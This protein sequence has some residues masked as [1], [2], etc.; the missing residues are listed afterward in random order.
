MSQDSGQ[1]AHL[2]VG[3]LGDG[4][5]GQRAKRSEAKGYDRETIFSSA[6]L[7]SLLLYR[8]FATVLSFAR[9]GKPSTV[10]TYYIAADECEWDCAPDG[11]DKMTGMG[12]GGWRQDVY[13]AWAA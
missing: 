1:E 6:D 2:R 4:R 13:G 3:G 12:F 9:S 11:V 10:H 7:I 8:E 5:P